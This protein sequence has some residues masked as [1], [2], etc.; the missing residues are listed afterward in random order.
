MEAQAGWLPSIRT[1]FQSPKHAMQICSLF[2]LCSDVFRTTYCQQWA[3]RQS[4]TVPARQPSAPTHPNP[5]YCV[6]AV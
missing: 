5:L 4:N 3:W 2:I 1:V 6:D